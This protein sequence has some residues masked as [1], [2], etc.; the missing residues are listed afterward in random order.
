MILYITIGEKWEERFPNHSI[1]GRF[2]AGNSKSCSNTS[3]CLMMV[4]KRRG[5]GL[6]FIAS[7]W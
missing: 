1:M 6:F 2:V 5:T 3:V 7:V 4:I